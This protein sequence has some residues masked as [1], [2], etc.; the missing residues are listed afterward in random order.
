MFIDDNAEP[1]SP[2]VRRAMFI[3]DNAEPVAL[4]QEGDVLI[5]S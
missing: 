2:S 5:K 1:D 4:R 3:D